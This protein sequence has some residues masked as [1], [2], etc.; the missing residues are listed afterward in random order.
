MHPSSR[1]KG[2]SKKEEGDRESKREG[3]TA[4]DWE[5][6]T[7]LHGDT[8]RHTYWPSHRE[9]TQRQRVRSDGRRQ[10]KDHARNG[11]GETEINIYPPA[12][13]HTY[14]HT[15]MQLH[16]CVCVCV[17]VFNPFRPTS[18][19]GQWP[20]RVSILHPH[21]VWKYL[22]GLDI[23]HKRLVISTYINFPSSASNLLIV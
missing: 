11:E 2:Q 22:W 23:E 6:Y 17:C 14:R 12:V 19:V 7:E 16:V 4:C 10:R 5:R 3:Q 9:C 20:N 13:I 1:A 21:R 8:K 15:H 18:H